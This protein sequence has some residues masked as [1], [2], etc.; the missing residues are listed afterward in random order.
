M[1]AISGVAIERGEIDELKLYRRVAMRILPLSILCYFFSYLDRI[2]ISFAKTQMQAELG[3]SDAAYGFAASIFFVGYVLFELPSSIG[4]RKYGAPAWLCRIMISWGLATAAIVFAY[5]EYTLYFLRFLI[6]VMEAGFAPAILFYLA[7]WFPKKKIASINGI[8]LIAAPLSGAIGAPIA[9]VILHGLHGVLGLSGWHW[10]FI[11]SGVPCAFLGLVTVWK[12]DRDIQSA[13]WLEPAE[14]AFLQAEVSES[15]QGQSKH[16][17]MWGVL[18][19]R[20]VAVFAVLYFI[21]KTAAY[22]LNF[23]MPD[24]IAR[25]GVTDQMSVGF[26]TAMPYTVAVFAMIGVTR[27][28]DKTGNRRTPTWCCLLVA[29]IGYF[30]ACLYSDNVVVMMLALTIATAGS[31]VAVPVFWALPQSTFSGM[32]IATGIAAINS[33]G[34]LSGMIVP[35]WVG[36]INDATG[37]S[38]LGMMSIAPLLLIGV[39]IVLWF[40]PKKV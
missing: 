24:L 28:S 5:N 34:Q 9:G 3:L 15:R 21:I 20:E 40:V 23:W 22:G 27:F 30:L 6:G 31:F 11:I 35:V 14:K 1:S 17:S 12:L 25:S 19:T 18:F 7:C 32:A 16:G 4:L 2:N 33:V 26:L 39:A 36:F 38:Y 37:V 29:C 13:K 10:L 8:F